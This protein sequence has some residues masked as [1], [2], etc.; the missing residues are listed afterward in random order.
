MEDLNTGIKNN[1]WIWKK[2]CERALAIQSN[3]YLVDRVTCVNLSI[4]SLL[5]FI[6]AYKIILETL[7]FVLVEKNSN[8]LYKKTYCIANDFFWKFCVYFSKVTTVFKVLLFIFGEV[9]FR[10]QTVFFGIRR[11][12]FIFF[13]CFTGKALKRITK[14]SKGW[15]QYL[16][17]GMQKKLKFLIIITF[18]SI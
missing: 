8:E 12:F 6:S 7:F 18:D 13:V 3:S 2:N 4:D 17:Q 1:K 16:I 11:Y 14:F 15:N 10:R 5:V 9:F